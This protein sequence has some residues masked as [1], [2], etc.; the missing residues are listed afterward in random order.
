MPVTSFFRGFEEERSATFVQAG[1]GL[2]IE[3]RGTRAGHQYQ[4]LGHSPHGPVSVEPYLITLTDKS[5][6]FPTFQHSGLEF[7]YML[8]GEQ[9]SAARVAGLAGGRSKRSVSTPFWL[10]VTTLQPA[11]PTSSGAC[12]VLTVRERLSPKQS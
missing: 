5:D 9:P 1:Q 4:L 2:P 12:A 10:T 11:L 7:L 8:E 6:V 3:R